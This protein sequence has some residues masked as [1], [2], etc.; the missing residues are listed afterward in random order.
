MTVL[1]S[2]GR[3]IGQALYSDRSEIA[4]RLLTHG[5]ERADAALWT[6]RLARLSQFRQSLAHR[7][8]RVP[9]GPRRGRSPA[10]ARSSIGTATTWWS[11]RCRKAPI[12]WCPDITRQ[13]VELLHPAGILARNDPR[14]RLLEGLEQRVD[15]LHGTVPETVEVREGPD[16]VPGRSVSRA[17]DRAVPR[18]ARESR[19]RESATR[20][21][22]CS[23]RSA[24]TA[25][26][27]WRWR[28]GAPRCSRS[29]SPRMRSRVSR[30]T[31]AATAWRMSR[32]A[33]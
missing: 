8:D 19:R 14:V 16:R 21:A 18:S 20:T 2:R 26:S 29:T 12:G 23:T 31:R 28:R 27:R 7:R 30:R 33:R 17:E 9:P 5:T 3:A 13:L 4:L 15:V 22:A 24:T 10:V 11:R 6:R 1:G 25:A 32:R